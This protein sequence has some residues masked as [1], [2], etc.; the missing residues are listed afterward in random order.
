MKKM[1]AVLAAGLALGGFG[2]VGPGL[3]DEEAKQGANAPYMQGLGE[4][5]LATQLHHNKI[6]FA[7]DAG[8]WELA[9]YEFDELKEGLSNGAKYYPTLDDIAVADL[10]KA[11]IDGPLDKLDKAI[12][13]KNK[14]EFASAYTALTNA[15]TNC[16]SAAKHAFI[17]IQKPTAPMITNQNYAVTK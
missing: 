17:K 10:M 11:N 14:G 7:G 6:F 13:A 9:A 15:C 2:L 8:N 4:F 12:E 3:A 1:V 5:M 16:H